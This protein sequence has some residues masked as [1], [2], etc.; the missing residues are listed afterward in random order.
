ME[1]RLPRR[2]A[3]VFLLAVMVLFPGSPSRA[4]ENPEKPLT[5]YT[6]MTATTPQ[7]PLWAAIRSGWPAGRELVVEYWKT[8]DDLRGLVLAGKGDL[9]VGHLEGFAQAAL[10]GAPVTLVA[11]TGWKKFY[12]VTTDYA[13]SP[14]T[15]EDIAEALRKEGLPLAVAPQD[16]P[17]IGILEELARRGGP[18]FAIEP[19]PSQQAMLSMLRG[20][21]SCVLLPEPLVSALLAKKSSLRIAASLEIEISGR[22]GGSGRLPLVGVAVKS[23]LVRDNPLLVRELVRAMEKAA[24]E[25]AGR[26]AE[27]AVAV[28]PQSVREAFDSKVLEASLSRDLIFVLPAHEARAEA[29]SFLRMVLREGR[30]S[31]GLTLPETF[32]LPDPE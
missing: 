16:S 13:D 28:L 20:S 7:I 30:D 27:E 14:R 11:V 8:L 32:F 3:A 18:S 5:L 21:R 29:L 23:S 24:L 22:F 2:F 4:A 1:R 9:W 6:A 10:R 25:L 17:A 19:M 15:L 12:F 31:A 26:P